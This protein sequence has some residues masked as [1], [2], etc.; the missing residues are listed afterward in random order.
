M[1]RPKKLLAS[2]LIAA[3]F[4]PLATAT[5]STSQNPAVVYNADGSANC[6]KNGYGFSD[7]SGYAPAHSC[8]HTVPQEGIENLP[9]AL[10]EVNPSL[11]E[12]D[13]IDVENTSVLSPGS[14]VGRD[15]YAYQPLT[16]NEPISS[17]SKEMT[18]NFQ[19][20]N[21]AISIWSTGENGGQ[22]GDVRYGAHENIPVYTV[23][24]SN[25]HQNYIWVQATDG[26]AVNVPGY[27]KIMAGK[28]PFPEW[29]LKD[30]G[31]SGDK[32]VAIYDKATGI[33]RSMFFFGGIGEDGKFVNTTENPD[34][35]LKHTEDGL[36]IYTYSS[37]GYI[38]GEPNFQGLG[39]RNYWAT[40]QGSTSSVAGMAN[41]LTQIGVDEIRA[42][43]INH[44][45]SM[46][47][48]DY[49]EHP[50]SFP[51]KQSDGRINMVVSE[52]SKALD[53]SEYS[54]RFRVSKFSSGKIDAG[55][56]DKY[57]S[58]VQFLANRGFIEL[59]KNF[60]IVSSQVS[61]DTDA[62]A[63]ATQHGIPVNHIRT[64]QQYLAEG[65]MLYV[66]DAPLPYTPKT[67]QRFTIPAD[68]DVEALADKHGLSEFDRMRLRAIQKY[69]GILTD[70]NAFIHAFNLEAAASYAPYAR[71][72]KN[73]YKEDPEIVEKLKGSNSHAFPWQAVV[74]ID[75]DF[76]GWEGDT[77]VKDTTQHWNMEL[78]E[79]Q[80]PTVYLPDFY[81]DQVYAG[82]EIYLDPNAQAIIPRG[83]MFNVP[84]FTAK[85]EAAEVAQ[86]HDMS[87]HFQS[88]STAEDARQVLELNTLGY[89]VVDSTL[90]RLGNT[91]IDTTTYNLNNPTV[92]TTL[93]SKL[94]EAGLEEAYRTKWNVATVDPA[95]PI[96]RTDTAKVARGQSTVIDPMANDEAYMGAKAHQR[97][98]AQHENGWGRITL[99]NENGED[100]SSLT[101]DGVTYTVTTDNKVVVDAGSADLGFVKPVQY[102]TLRF[103][104]G[105][106]LAGLAASASDGQVASQWSAPGTIQAQVYSSFGTEVP[107]VDEP[108][109]A[110]TPE[111]T[112]APTVEPTVAPS[113]EPSVVPTD[114]PTAEPTAEPSPVPSVAPSAEPSSEPTVEPTVEPT[115]EPTVAPEPTDPVQPV[116]D[117]SANPTDMPVPTFEPTDRIEPEAP[118]TEETTPSSE[119]AEQAPV[120]NPEGELP[121]AEEEI[122]S[123]E[124]VPAPAVTTPA[125]VVPDTGLEGQVV[126]AADPTTQ[127]AEADSQPVQGKG[128][129]VV[130]ALV[131]LAA[132]GAGA[133]AYRSRHA[134]S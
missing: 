2:T 34:T 15:T 72:G 31:R 19:E 111:P 26:R 74:W 37:G 128:V 68:V 57:R 126:A 49:H 101:S 87:W 98:A 69:G 58:S 1:P 127:A 16:G 54:K 93:R 21:Y 99:V 79:G 91:N 20:S 13:L 14:Q 50:P 64:V 53:G 102:K 36:P 59:D 67:G 47:A 73:V 17:V 56:N 33:W 129:V 107:V 38:L 110:P 65:D 71:Y 90:G 100:V 24:S 11:T 115:T 89:T 55:L 112:V 94:R 35:P 76:S 25:P 60:G 83:M 108:T 32:S 124:N 106:T 7:P 28:I 113:V 45:I 8:F 9:P 123:V 109:P 117:P 48:A 130:V 5:A 103:G 12:Q 63:F 6:V 119:P 42:G 116:T 96:A 88:G 82:Q 114:V 77:G 78:E 125:G 44:A 104:Q 131:C 132:I 22:I 43:E 4:I 62:Q 10:A 75:E 85:F 66:T 86:H 120:E 80:L 29:A 39:D 84:W 122:V 81:N 97:T 46:T 40:L 70:R 30:R 18:A 27:D 51:A 134:K 118:V 95:S 121:V 41:E 61:V 92:G 52:G 105:S 3:A 23:D 133:G